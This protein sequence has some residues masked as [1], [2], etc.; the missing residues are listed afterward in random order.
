[1]TT[2]QVKFVD[3]DLPKG[4]VSVEPE[5]MSLFARQRLDDLLSTPTPSVLDA[6]RTHSVSLYD[7]GVRTGMDWRRRANNDVSNRYNNESWREYERMMDKHRNVLASAKP[8]TTAC[9]HLAYIEGWIAG[10]SSLPMIEAVDRPI[11]NP[12][13]PTKHAHQVNRGSY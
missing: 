5:L 12:T 11:N 3:D 2:N 1:M 13:N 4:H 8:H 6:L 10:W 7:L 9:K